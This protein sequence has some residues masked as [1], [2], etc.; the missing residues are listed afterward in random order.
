MNNIQNA[1]EKLSV[2]IENAPEIFEN[3][4]EEEFALQPWLGMWSKK[5]LLGHLIDCAAMCHQRIVRIQYEKEP[6]IFYNRKQWIDL[7]HY[8]AAEVNDLVQ[9]W[10]WYNKHLLHVITNIPSLNLEKIVTLRPGNQY[11][12]KS[13][14]VDYVEQVENNFMQIFG[15]QFLKQIG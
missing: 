8:N 7:Q 6:I 15:E 2:L 9:L 1:I 11:N 5:Q 12:L 4:N 3:R 13:L 14:I 10:K